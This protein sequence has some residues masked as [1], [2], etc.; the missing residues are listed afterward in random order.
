MNRVVQ[1][2]CRVPLRV[3]H[4]GTARGWGLRAGRAITKGEFVCE[5]AGEV[6]RGEEVRRRRWGREEG[7]GNY[8]LCVREHV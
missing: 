3:F 2:G 5:Y 6:V 1:H 7:R 8:V 4:T